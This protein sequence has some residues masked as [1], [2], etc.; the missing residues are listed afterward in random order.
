MR[1]EPLVD[2]TKKAMT[3]CSLEWQLSKEGMGGW[4]GFGEKKWRNLIL[5]D[6]EQDL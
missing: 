5:R 2:T 4:I 3:K 6:R 1:F